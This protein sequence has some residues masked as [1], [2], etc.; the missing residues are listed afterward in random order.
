M[1]QQCISSIIQVKAVALEGHSRKLPWDFYPVILSVW[2]KRKLLSQVYSDI[3]MREARHITC[4]D[5][6]LFEFSGFD[7]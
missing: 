4:G 6:R 1:L 5:L 3:N 7:V 2:T